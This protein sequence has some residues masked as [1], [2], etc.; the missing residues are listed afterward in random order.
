MV[1]CVLFNTPLIVI[2]ERFET[3]PL[4]HFD[5]SEKSYKYL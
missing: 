5:R 3:P 4:C 1:K 2:G